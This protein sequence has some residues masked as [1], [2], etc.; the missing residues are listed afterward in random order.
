M[1]NQR[2]TRTRIINTNFYT[3]DFGVD[4]AA[5]TSQTSTPLRESERR[6]RPRK[7]SDIINDEDE[8]QNQPDLTSEET[9]GVRLDSPP[10]KR[11]CLDSAGTGQCRMPLP[12]FATACERHR[13]SDRKA[14]HLATALLK[15]FQKYYNID[16]IDASPNS[17]II[18]RSKVRRERDKVK[19][20]LKIF[21]FYFINDFF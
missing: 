3:D 7:I 11:M 14:A 12:E 13:M 15:D 18:D 2:N 20:G 4:D 17:L 21:K 8:V 9:L 16:K 1:T 10:T 6:G 5:S 19:K